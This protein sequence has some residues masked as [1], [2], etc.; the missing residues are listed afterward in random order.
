M[1]LNVNKSNGFELKRRRTVCPLTE[2]QFEDRSYHRSRKRGLGS[3]QKQTLPISKQKKNI[4]SLKPKM[5]NTESLK[6]NT[7]QPLLIANYDLF[8][9]ENFGFAKPTSH[10]Y[11]KLRLE[12]NP[13]NLTDHVFPKDR[14]SVLNSVEVELFF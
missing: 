5:T 9:E 2:K 1:N 11:S 3:T 14:F 4:E 8:R 7:K 6:I 10:P 13:C 12:K